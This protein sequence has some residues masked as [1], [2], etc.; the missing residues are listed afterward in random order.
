MNRK[1]KNTIGM[2]SARNHFARPKVAGSFVLTA[3]LALVL[4]SITVATSPHQ[5]FAHAVP[6]SYS[7]EPNTVFEDPDSVPSRLIISFSERPDPR[8]SYI[9][10]L[11]AGNERIDNND[12]AITSTNAREAA[13]TL[14]T[15]RLQGDSI[16]SVS[17][18]TLS[19]DDGHITE[20]AYVFGVGN[21]DISTAGEQAGEETTYV[22]STLDALLKW[23]MIVAQTAIVGGALA[24]L[25]LWRPF[26][27]RDR[28]TNDVQ[29][30][31]ASSRR[32]AVIIAASAAAIACFGTALLFVQA[33][34]LA[35]A[36][37]SD[38][39]SI[40][41][42]LISGSP[43]GSVWILRIATSA[44][45]IAVSIGYYVLAKR[46]HHLRPAPFLVAILV[47]G[48]ASVFSNSMLSH[49]SAAPFLPEV[50]IFSDW[51]H[52]MAVS[53]WVG[54]LFYFSAVGMK[55]M[56]S[57]RDAVQI[58]RHLSLVLPRFSILATISLGIIGITGIYMAWI[59]IHNFDFLFGTAYGTSLIVKLSAAAPMVA[60]G[61][62]HQLVL[63]KSMIMVAADGRQS[64]AANNDDGRNI[65]RSR[66]DAAFR[67][68]KTVKIE[69]LVGIVVLLAAS[70]LTITSP[71]SQQHHQS[72]GG[73]GTGYFN[74]VTI[75]NTEVTFGISPFQVGV[76]T[77]TVALRDEAGQPPS[78]I[79]NVF[80]RF[81]NTQAGI[82]PIIATL[83]ETGDGTYSVTGAFLSQPGT[84][85]IDFIAQRT[86]AY[87]LNHSFE[88]TLSSSSTGGEGHSGHDQPSEEETPPSS[89]DA[90]MT[91]TALQPSGDFTLAAILLSIGIAGA[92]AYSVI[93]SKQQLARTVRSLTQ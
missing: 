50:A 57:N 91:D 86:S 26:L 29:D 37:N 9:R 39:F 52:F 20:G 12:L 8:T 6:V 84:W 61:G 33:G 18:R 32:L 44:A 53:A 70:F 31:A 45:I 92:S 59:H 93:R 78:N 62:Y 63:H 40:A 30:S 75:D 81:T 34:N 1:V 66:R 58:N 19:L 83:E 48:G 24:H 89:E 74:T 11:T 67:F 49:N 85:K 22:T 71:P 4:F 79:Q 16:Y 64:I 80:M 27:H 73:S 41:Q 51:L 55:M 46:A 15:S 13:V 17:W 43:S 72:I 10:V 28:S 5:A 36:A 69:S 21:I 87:D 90:Q 3:V 82:G 60:L 77:F 23:P 14:D 76:N 38:Y 56:S 88:E 7:L 68:G 65:A 42:S 2:G 25:L 47:A 54:G 35:T